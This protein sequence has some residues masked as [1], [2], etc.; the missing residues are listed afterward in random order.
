MNPLKILNI[1][2]NHWKHT[3]S[4]RV[5]I[6]IAKNPVTS[7]HIKEWIASSISKIDHSNHK[8]GVIQKGEIKA[9]MLIYSIAFHEVLNVIISKQ[10]KEA[11]NL[12]QDTWNEFFNQICHEVFNAKESHEKMLELVN[13]FC[14]DQAEDEQ[15]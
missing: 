3:V 12:L 15:F 8:S 14:A 2:M 9:K 10:S 4:Y 6:Y 11:A 1:F 5:F 7:K 13:R